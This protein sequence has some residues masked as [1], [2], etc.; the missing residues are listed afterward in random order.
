MHM[1]TF[2]VPA[3]LHFYILHPVISIWHSTTDSLDLVV[4]SYKYLVQF[5][6]I[7]FVSD[8]SVY[9][10][11]ILLRQVS[12]TSAFLLLWLPDA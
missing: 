9:L 8:G 2:A 11:I 3:L 12:H 7:G 5:I 1:H 10:L 4:K 6:C